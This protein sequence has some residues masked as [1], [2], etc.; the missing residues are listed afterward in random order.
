[1]TMPPMCMCG[2]RPSRA[3]NEASTAVS[4][5]RC[6]CAIPGSPDS[7][8]GRHPTPAPRPLQG[9][10]S[11]PVPVAAGTVPSAMA[12][13]SDSDDDGGGRLSVKLLVV[14]LVGQLILFGGLIALTIHGFPFL[15]GGDGG[16]GGGGGK[17]AA[18]APAGTV[19][20]A[21]VDRFDA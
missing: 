20:K 19:P 4:R 17:A 9:L 16:G 18:T 10:R 15:G 12:G 21:E 8:R 1:M 3:R 13:P 11:A 5:S 14:A 6:C 7:R 2:A